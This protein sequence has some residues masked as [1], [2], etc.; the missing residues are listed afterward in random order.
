MKKFLAL[1]L[2]LAAVFVFMPFSAYAQET[3]VNQIE[4]HIRHLEALEARL[5]ARL[6]ELEA[7]RGSF[8]FDADGW[9]GRG[10]CWDEDGNFIGPGLGRGWCW[11]EDGSFIGPRVR[12]RWNGSWGTQNNAADFEPGIG[13]GGRWGGRGMMRGF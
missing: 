4:E 9:R 5:E 12:G 10:W 6:R 2:T 8:S 3:D 1:V 11:D 7:R 13:P